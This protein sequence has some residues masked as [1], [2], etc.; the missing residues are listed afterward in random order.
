MIIDI[1]SR[2]FVAWEVWN[3]ENGELAADLVE[4][5]VLSEKVKYKP[6]VLH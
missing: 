4:R 2:K 5:A 3:E 1:F 6:L